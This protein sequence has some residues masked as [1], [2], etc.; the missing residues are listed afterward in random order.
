[1]YGHHDAAVPGPPGQPCPRLAS[2][3]TESD[4]I[5]PRLVT[6]RERLF[7]LVR[8]YQIRA[9]PSSNS[10]SRAPGTA[11]PRPSWHRRR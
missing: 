1:M 8:R 11:T 4:R 7:N 2:Y 10:E 3:S 5:G 6:R 9:R